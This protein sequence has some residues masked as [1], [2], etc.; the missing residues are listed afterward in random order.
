MVLNMFLC[1]I[2]H[3]TMYPNNSPKALSGQGVETFSDILRH[4][5]TVLLF[6]FCFL[7]VAG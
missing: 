3:S 4:Y 6:K 2:Q 7:A 1:I 5:T